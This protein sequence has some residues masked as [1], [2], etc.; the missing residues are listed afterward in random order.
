[1]FSWALNRYPGPCPWGCG[2]QPLS[3][4]RASKLRPCH[5]VQTLAIDRPPSRREARGKEEVRGEDRRL[6]PYTSTRPKVKIC[7]GT[8]S[9]TR[10]GLHP[11]THVISG[12]CDAIPCI[13]RSTRIACRLTMDRPEERSFF[14]ASGT[15]IT[16]AR[17]RFGSG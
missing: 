13:T 7:P 5:P 12:L 3:Q 8:L 14:L 11:G 1:M 10:R 9:S 6:D 17:V 2:H 16:V 4:P 15:C